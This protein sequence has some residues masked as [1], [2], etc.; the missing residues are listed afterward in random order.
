MY[1]RLDSLLKKHG[2]TAYRLAK[3]VGMSQ[4]SLSE[5]KRGN[6]IP[7]YDKLVKIAR[8]FNVPV[9]YLTGAETELPDPGG[10]TALLDKLTALLKEKLADP[11]WSDEQ[12]KLNLALFNSL[13]KEKQAEALRYLR[14]LVSLQEAEKL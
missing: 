7:K 2:I 3:E 6:S 5:W 9:S 12:S 13:S 10:D 14:Y 8:Y 1:E 11:E 4:S